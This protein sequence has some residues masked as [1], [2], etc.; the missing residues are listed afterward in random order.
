MDVVGILVLLLVA[1]VVGALGE[2]LG[3]TKVPG[4]WVGSIVVGLVGAWLGTQ[5]VHIGPTI[6]GIQIIPAV[7]GAVLL[8][9]ILRV[10]LSLTH[11]TRTV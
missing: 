9:L 8:V 7:L 4:G 5:L 3:G 6:A 2:M 11:R 1:F 10:I